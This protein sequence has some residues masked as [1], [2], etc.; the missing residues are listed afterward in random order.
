MV[1]LLDD[2]THTMSKQLSRAQR[3]RFEKQRQA[4]RI[5]I[6]EHIKRTRLNATPGQRRSTNLEI[7]RMLDDERKEKLFEYMTRFVIPDQS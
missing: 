2:K 5:I 6:I 4:I 7:Y 3:Q 1:H